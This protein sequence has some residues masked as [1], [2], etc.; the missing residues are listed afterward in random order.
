MKDFERFSRSGEMQEL[1]SQNQL[2]KISSPLKT[3]PA[4]LS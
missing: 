3:C 2:L 1:G 4:S